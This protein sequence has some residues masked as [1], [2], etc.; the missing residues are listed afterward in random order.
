MAKH[1]VLCEVG[2]QILIIY[3]NEILETMYL[4][5]AEAVSSTLQRRSRCDS[6]SRWTKWHRERFFSQYFGILLSVPF[7]QCCTLIFIYM[8]PLPENTREWNLGHFKEME[9]SDTGKH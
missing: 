6:K 8:L 3:Y 4:T 2:A 9:I 7:H 5:V 1:D